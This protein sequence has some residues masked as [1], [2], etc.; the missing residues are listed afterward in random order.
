MAVNTTKLGQGF[1]GLPSGT[2]AERPASPADGYTRW[3]TTLGVVESYHGSTQ[4]WIALSNKFQAEGGTITTSG[5]YK[6]HTFTSSGN[7]IVTSGS[8]SVE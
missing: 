7:F 2:T 1:V 8:Q 4:G 3:N 5:S 6:I